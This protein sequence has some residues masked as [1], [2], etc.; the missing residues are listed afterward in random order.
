MTRIHSSP[1]MD[2]TGWGPSAPPGCKVTATWV[3][4]DRGYD[5]KSPS[6]Y[7]GCVQPASAVY[8]DSIIY[9]MDA[10]KFYLP[11]ASQ[12]YKSTTYIPFRL[13]K[14]PDRATVMKYR[15]PV[16]HKDLVWSP[17]QFTVQAKGQEYFKLYYR[18][19]KDDVERYY[20][21]LRKRPSRFSW[22]MDQKKM[23]LSLRC[24]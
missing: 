10:S 13:I 2:M 9:D 15:C 3:G 23:A 8:F 20:R 21:S 22:R 17:L 14:S 7:A 19:P 1:P 12:R 4:V 18:G 6:D 16:R 5:A 11:A 24:R